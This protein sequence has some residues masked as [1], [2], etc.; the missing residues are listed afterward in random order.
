VRHFYDDLTTAGY[1]G[2]GGP[3]ER[4]RYHPGYYA[5]YVFDPDGNNIEVVDHHL[6]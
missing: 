6:T 2:N 3:H 5:S 1:R 4:A